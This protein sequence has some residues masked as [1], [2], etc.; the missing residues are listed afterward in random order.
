MYLIAQNFLRRLCQQ[1]AAAAPERCIIQ[2]RIS[3]RESANSWPLRRVIDVSSPTGLQQERVG[4]PRVGR[5]VFV[6]SLSEHPVI[7]DLKF[8]GSFFSQRKVD[9]SHHTQN[10]MQYNT[11]GT[12]GQCRRTAL[13]FLT[14]PLAPSRVFHRIFCGLSILVRL[15]VGFHI[16]LRVSVLSCLLMRGI[17]VF[18]VFVSNV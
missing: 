6:E 14:E 17:C 2:D 18:R 8:Q 16:T 1:L 12:E 13:L 5:Y 9:T 4:E 7:E 15:G 3:T 10:N 11:C